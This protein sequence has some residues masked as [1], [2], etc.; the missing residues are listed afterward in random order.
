MRTALEETILDTTAREEIFGNMRKLADW[1]RNQSGNP[2]DAKAGM[3][4]IR[5]SACTPKD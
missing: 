4:H 2:H 5:E 3:A 1:M